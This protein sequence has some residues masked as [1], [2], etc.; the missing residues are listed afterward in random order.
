MYCD[1]N[2]PK[3]LLLLCCNAADW[4]ACDPLFR[5]FLPLTFP[6]KSARI[7][8]FKEVPVPNF[9]LDK[10]DDTMNFQVHVRASAS[11]FNTDT[12][13]FL[14]NSWASRPLDLMVSFP[15]PLSVHASKLYMEKKRTGLKNI[16]V[17]RLHLGNHSEEIFHA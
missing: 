7:P 14:S 2:I 12:K 9:L 17:I 5:E 4:P 8:S 15:P 11:M 6:D 1:G 3:L 16:K 10:A 13:A